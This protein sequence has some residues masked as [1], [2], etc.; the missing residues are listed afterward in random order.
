MRKNFVRA[1]AAPVAFL[2][3]LAFLAT[4]AAWFLID[5]DLALP[6][7]ERVVGV[8]LLLACGTVFLVLCMIAFLLYVSY[9]RAHRA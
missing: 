8:E 4:C 9:R 2:C 3:V 7:P 5:A 1:L 6:F